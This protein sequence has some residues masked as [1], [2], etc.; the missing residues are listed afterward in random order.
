MEVHKHNLFPNGR[1]LPR[2]GLEVDARNDALETDARGLQTW[3]N[4]NAFPECIEP[5]CEPDETSPLARFERDGRYGR[6]R[7]GSPKREW[8]KVLP[9]R[10]TTLCLSIA[11]VLTT[12]V[13]IVLGR[14][15]VASYKS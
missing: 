10:R 4:G 5:Q 7:I 12:V 13:I 8:Y 15:L 3:Y 9:L 11:L 1:P 14:F 6:K 2:A